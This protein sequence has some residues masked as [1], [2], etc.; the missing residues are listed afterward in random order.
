MVVDHRKAPPAA[1][2]K[3]WEPAAGSSVV[4][5]VI[6]QDD[7]LCA[8]IIAGRFETHAFDAAEVRSLRGFASQVA[9]ALDHARLLRETVESERRKKELEIARE[10]QLNLLPKG[11][12][13]FAGLD[14]DGYSNPASEVGGDYF[15]YLTLQ[16]GNPAVVVGDVAGHGMPA[17]MLMAVAKS[18]IHT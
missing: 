4:V 9:L 5:P 3:V 16:N 15:D 17:G 8:V 12:P 2:D 14:I 6:T 13:G 18:A 11:P 10:L 1:L 7:V